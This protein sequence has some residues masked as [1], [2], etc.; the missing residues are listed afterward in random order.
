MFLP[1]VLYQIYA[2]AQEVPKA[3]I[4]NG[5]IDAVIYLP[6]PVNGYYRGVRFDWSGV[7]S[8]LNYKGHSFFGQW[9]KTYDPKLHDAI[10]GPVEAF[11]PLGYEEAKVGEPFIKIGVGMLEKPDTAAYHFSKPYKI[12]NSGKW[13]ISQDRDQI[14]FIHG[15]DDGPYPYHYKKAVRLRE[16][17][18]IIEHTLSN[19]GSH[20]IHTQVFDHNFFVIDED[21]IGSGYTV[22]FPFKIEADASGLKEFAVVEDNQIRF[23]KS[24]GEND[25]VRLRSI[26]GFRPLAEDYDI[27]V[28]NSNTGAGVRITSDSPLSNMIFW[29]ADKTL[30]PEPYIDIEVGPADSF[31]WTIT[32]NYYT[33]K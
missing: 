29:A 19:K 28:E 20:P 12:V 33:W 25:R 14:E 5:V 18:M 2:C 16:N 32:Y 21:K 7:V 8:E 4:S 1:L 24:L 3:Q 15:L 30:C 27:V 6:D 10:M 9:F 13:M 26:E 17:K 31:S 23:I 22:M 11:D